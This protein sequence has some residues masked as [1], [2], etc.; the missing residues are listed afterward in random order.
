MEKKKKERKKR[1][2]K[3][4]RNFVMFMF[5]TFLIEFRIPNFSTKK[6]TL[7]ET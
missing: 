5:V 3:L 4:F 7:N 2:E 1:L 6:P